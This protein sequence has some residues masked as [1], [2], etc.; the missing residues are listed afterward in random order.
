[1]A[2][3][4]I[5]P[6]PGLGERD[7]RRAHHAGPP[8]VATP[9]SNESLLATAR[10]TDVEVE[11]RTPEFIDTA[12]AYTDGMARNADEVVAMIGRR[13]FDERMAKRTRSLRALDQGLLRR[14][15]VV[16]RRP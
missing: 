11:D 3:L 15:L 10:F 7:R 14:S 13:D 1:M 8:C 6:T 4:T 9:T 12:A 16:A 2:F 5:H